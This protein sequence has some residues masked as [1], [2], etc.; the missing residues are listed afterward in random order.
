MGSVERFCSCEEGR[1]SADYPPRRPR[2]LPQRGVGPQLAL[3][4]G[5][6]HLAGCPVPLLPDHF[7]LALSALWSGWFISSSLT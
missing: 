1:P 7:H 2:R 5:G 3:P 4:P 6:A